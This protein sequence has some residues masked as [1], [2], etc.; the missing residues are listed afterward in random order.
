MVSIISYGSGNVRAIRNIYDQL[1][2]ENRIVE[3]PSDF[4]QETTKIIMPGVGAFDETMKSL[5]NSGFRSL[6]DEKVLHD[7]IPVLGICVGMQILA[8]GSEEGELEG[9]G[10][11]KGLVKK[12]D[13][14]KLDFVPKVPHLGWNSICA[15][16]ES[17]LLN[18]IDY[19][20]GFYFI[21]SY[22]YCCKNLSDILTTTFYGDSFASAINQG[23][24]YG[25]QFHPEKS[26]ANGIQLLKN[27][28]TL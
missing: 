16:R 3:K 9:L 28:Y 26:H 13:V 27:F 7:K 4:P 10:W 12:F 18:G 20:H 15:T 8:E 21:H 23:N 6:L 19:G 1:N 14:T 25:T 24:I 22:F 11:I 17:E 2:I 5:N